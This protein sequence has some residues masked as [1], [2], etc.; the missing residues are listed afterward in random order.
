MSTD[1]FSAQADIINQASADP[2]P[3]MVSP[4]DPHV[5]LLRGIYQKT[6]EVD[7]W[8]DV[9]EVRE[10]TGEDEEYLDAVARKDKDISFTKYMGMLLQRGVLSIGDLDVQKAPQVVDKLIMPD[11]EML[12]LAMVK[13]TYGPTRTIRAVCRACGTDNTIVIE[14][15]EDFAIKQPEFDIRKDIKVDTSKGVVRLRLP[16]GEDM[17]AIQGDKDLTD[18]QTNTLMLAR[19]SVWDDDKSEKERAEWARTLSIADRKLLL[20]C[21]LDISAIGP[22]LRGVDTHCAECGQ[23]M[24]IALDWVSL[25]FG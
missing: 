10:L 19:C 9:A 23:D 24:A 17:E 11:R 7:K 15:D 5:Q 18:A 12:F 3:E 25:L 21:L 8:H 4:P 16:N 14:L 20:N 2:V 22:D 1:D 13:A 6:D